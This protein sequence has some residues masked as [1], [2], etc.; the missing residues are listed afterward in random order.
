MDSPTSSQIGRDMSN[1]DGSVPGPEK[2]LG[3]RLRGFRSARKLTLRQVATRAKVS[4]SFL[5]QVERGVSSVSISTLHSIATSLGITIADLFDASGYSYRVLRVADRPMISVLNVQKYMLTRPP[6]QSLEVLECVYEPGSSTGGSENI[7]GDSQE[8]VLML[9]GSL[10]VKIGDEEHEMKIG[11]S[12]EYR[13]SLAHSATN[14]S[15]TIARALIIISP[16]SL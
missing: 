15:T 9:E 13:S 1:S 11:D 4:E 3:A 2:L 7:H 12:V 5:S 14:V 10:I 8:L 16:P 6:L